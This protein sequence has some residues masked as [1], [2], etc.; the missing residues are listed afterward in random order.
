MKQDRFGIQTEKEVEIEPTIGTRKYVVPNSYPFT[1]ISKL[2]KEA[3][4]EKGSPH[5]LF[6]KTK[7]DFILRHFSS[8]TMRPNKKVSEVSSILVILGLMRKPLQTQ[9]QVKT[10][11][12][13]KEYCNIL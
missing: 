3:K 10:Y 11:R 1:F 5:Y 9:S 8:Y 2:T 7:K 4:S 12:F 6:L 13:S